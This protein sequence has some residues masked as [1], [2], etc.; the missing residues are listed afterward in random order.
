M[1]TN[2]SVDIKELLIGTFPFLH[3]SEKTLENLYKKVQFLRYRMGQ[4]IA[5]RL[6]C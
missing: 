5:I 3:L 2:T 1:M 6:S 4:T